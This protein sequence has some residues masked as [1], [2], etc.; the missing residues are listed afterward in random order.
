MILRDFVRTYALL[1]IGGSALLLFLA[2]RHLDPLAPY[3]PYAFVLLCPLLHLFMLA[4][5]R[6]H[7]DP[8]APPEE[9]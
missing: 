1:L 9:R 3:A 8:G 5:H 7:A 6:D 4:G 2:S